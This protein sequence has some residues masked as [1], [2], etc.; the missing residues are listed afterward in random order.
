MKFQTTQKSRIRCRAGFALI[1]VMA[2]ILML[3]ILPA[4]I[5]NVPHNDPDALQDAIDLAVVD[6]SVGIIQFN[7]SPTFATDGFDYQVRGELL[8]HI[9]N[10]V[11]IGSP[12]AGRRIV[13]KGSGTHTNG[14]ILNI[15]TNGSGGPQDVDIEIENL[16]FTGGQ[17]AED[18]GAI[19]Y[20]SGGSLTLENCRVE[21]CNAGVFGGGVC[22]DGLGHQALGFNIVACEFENNTGAWG[23][24]VFAIGDSSPLPFL[25]VSGTLANPTTIKNNLANSGSFPG[26][27][28]HGGGIRAARM[29]VNI[30]GEADGNGNFG[31]EITDNRADRVDQ[32]IEFGRG[33]GISLQTCE[34]I[35]DGVDIARNVALSEGG[36]IY[37]EGSSP[38]RMAVIS[39]GSRLSSNMAF[40]AGGGGVYSRDNFLSIEIDSTVVIDGNNAFNS[41][42]GGGVFI[43]ESRSVVIDA[44]V[45]NNTAGV[46]GGGIFVERDP[47]DSSLEI[48]G[49]FEGNIAENGGG[50]FSQASA[51]VLEDATFD[52]NTAFE[53]GG[54]VRITESAV[55]RDSQFLGNTAMKGGGLFSQAPTQLLVGTTFNA[56]FAWSEGGGFHLDGSLLGG[57]FASAAITG[58]QFFSNQSFM[59]GGIFCDAGSLQIQNGSVFVGNFAM[60]SGGGI[61]AFSSQFN[62]GGFVSFFT[63]IAGVDGGGIA[64]SGSNLNSLGQ[65][66]M[67]SNGAGSRGGA[68]FNQSSFVTVIGGFE[69][70]GNSATKG[71]GIYTESFGPGNVPDPI[72]GSLTR[73]GSFGVVS[74]SGNTATEAGGGIFD[75]GFVVL[76]DFVFTTSGNSPDQIFRD[77]GDESI[78]ITDPCG[79]E[80]LN[81]GALV[82]LGDWIT[83]SS[84]TPQTFRIFNNSV[85]PLRIFDLEISGSSRFTLDKSTTSTD[86]PPGESTVFTVSFSPDVVGTENA[87]VTVISDDPDDIH[88]EIPIFAQGVASVGVGQEAYVK[89]SNSGASDLFGGAVSISGKTYVVGASSE[90]GDGSADT[91]NS[92]SNAGAAYVFTCDVGQTVQQAYLKASNTEAGDD[93]GY[94]VAI[95]GDTIVVGARFEDSGANVVNGVESD[96]SASGAGA[97]Y[98][99][100]REPFTGTWTQQAYLKASNAE[101]GDQFGSSVGIFGDTIVVGAPIEDSSATGVD[102]DESN[103]SGNNSG[104]AYVFVRDPA[105]QMWSQQAYLKASNS[106]ASDT[107]GSSLAISSDLIVIGAS[108]EDSNAT[109]I[110][111]DG[112][113]NSASSA[114]A[115]YVFRRQGVV[116]SEEA[117]LKAS[118]TEAGDAYGGSVS[119]SGDSLVVG[120]SYEDGV[121]TGVNGNEGNGS[122]RAGAAYVYDHDGISWSQA[123]YVKASTVDAHDSFGSRVSISGDAMMIGAYGEDSSATG[124]D[125]DQANNSIQFSGAAYL[126]IRS[127][128][129]WNQHAYFKASNTGFAD[130]F[131]R[132]G[133][134]GSSVIIGAM[135]EDSDENSIGGTGSNNSGSN[136]GAVYEFDLFSN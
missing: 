80:V 33:G 134:S 19:Y 2:S 57:S 92:A 17:V 83:A 114:G 108:N 10:L 7:P 69:I 27:I 100:V 104:A 117:Y 109:G 98:V 6:P 31:V 110:N 4:Q 107:F 78:A 86:L 99:F 67:E 85:D 25:N 125:G 36:G 70:L 56:N 95:S 38:E 128:G 103:N 111:G 42:S 123:A 53:N 62:F 58:C 26:S 49:Q 75:A 1:F 37:C 24:A 129:I 71:G 124:I 68:I 18:G 87:K 126:F 60:E 101:A 39:G 64:L 113:N 90:D 97:A 48:G 43:K 89:A 65:T 41:G 122:S 81:D 135:L 46:D 55:I 61:A 72:F 119:I 52:N 3:Q 131:G 35:A 136:A 22:F 76:E 28:P 23:G 130:F 73:Q 132:V 120:A 105:T 121:A 91:D 8:V 63:N 15:D 94:S 88:F 74:I 9:D 79:F 116:W 133:I 106:G 34:L 20:E 66:K 115:A 47:F 118:N 5:T 12:S 16:L 40:G 93:F 82:D 13:I 84:G 102:G 59:G 77:F 50:I 29:D 21:N 11:F 14:G 54:G 51:L 112:S 44:T 32:G 127:G 96:N 45:S 30:T